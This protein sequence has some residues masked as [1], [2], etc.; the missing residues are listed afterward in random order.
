MY[1]LLSS[2]PVDPLLSEQWLQCVVQDAGRLSCDVLP[3]SSRDAVNGV[4]WFVGSG[5]YKI[6]IESGDS[7]GPCRK[8]EKNVR[9]IE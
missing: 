4:K 7:E 8:V 3:Y 9:N 1:D 6:S 5:A 2:I